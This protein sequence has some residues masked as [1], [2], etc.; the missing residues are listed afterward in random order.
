MFLF[1][2]SRKR[3]AKAEFSALFNGYIKNKKPNK[4]NPLLIFVLKGKK[5]NSHIKKKCIT[6]STQNEFSNKYYEK[7]VATGLH[8]CSTLCIVKSV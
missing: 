1:G 3:P 8:K 6:C 7:T 4:T 2:H 5:Q